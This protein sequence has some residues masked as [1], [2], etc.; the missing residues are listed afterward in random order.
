M[1]TACKAGTVSNNHS[2]LY[3]LNMMGGLSEMNPLFGLKFHTKGLIIDLL[4][5]KPT[6]WWPLS[7]NKPLIEVLSAF[8]QYH[9]KKHP[10]SAHRW[11]P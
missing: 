6:P 8:P 10:S 4:C 1:D 11:A 5:L 7:H 9:E 3:L 2:E